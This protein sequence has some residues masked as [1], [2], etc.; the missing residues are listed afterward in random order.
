MLRNIHLLLRHI[1]LRCVAYKT[2]SSQKNALFY[3]ITFVTAVYGL[4]QP[5]PQALPRLSSDSE[6]LGAPEHD[7]AYSARCP[8]RLPAEL[9]G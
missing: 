5:H 3:S 4:F 2:S 1:H 8:R 9:D 7:S 6:M